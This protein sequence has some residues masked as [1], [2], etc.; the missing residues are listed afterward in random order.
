MYTKDRSFQQHN[1]YAD[2]SRYRALNFSL[3][4]SVINSW[5]DDQM[6]VDTRIHLLAACA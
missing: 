2:I 1:V 6:T 3:S 5:T 4:R